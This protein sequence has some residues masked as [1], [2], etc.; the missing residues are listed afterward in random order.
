MEIVKGTGL[1]K[2]VIIQNEIMY[3]KVLQEVKPDY[4]VHGD[5]WREGPEAA[6]VKML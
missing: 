5:N 3:D 6:S 2:E 1:V 4:V